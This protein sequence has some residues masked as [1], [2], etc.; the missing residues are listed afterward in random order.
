[1]V[2]DPSFTIFCLCSYCRFYVRNYQIPRKQKKI[3]VKQRQGFI[4]HPKWCN[5]RIYP[6]F[7]SDSVPLSLSRRGLETL[8][9]TLALP[10]FASVKPLSLLPQAPLSS[11]QTSRLGYWSRADDY[12]HYTEPTRSNQAL[13]GCKG[14]RPRVATR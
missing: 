1:M 14:P 9:I 4:V 7:S 10:V 6:P 12:N 2:T 8:K 11:T 13:V 3:T 5:F